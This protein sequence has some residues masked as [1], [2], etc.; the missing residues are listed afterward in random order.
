[1]N[2]QALKDQFNSAEAVSLIMD[3]Q[4][5][6]VR[7]IDVTS[8]NNSLPDNVA[9]TVLLAVESDVVWE[10]GLFRLGLAGEVI[11]VL[12]VPVNQKEHEVFYE[13]VFN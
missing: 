7:I 1:M 5:Y 10:Q 11:D 9:F 4:K 8:I 6:P 2:N 13:I 3:E 12:M